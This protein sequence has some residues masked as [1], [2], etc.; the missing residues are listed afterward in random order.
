MPTA[1][2]SRGASRPVTRP[3]LDD[4]P[5]LFLR[6][7]RRGDR[8]AREELIVRFLPLARK[9]A[10]RYVKPCEPIEDLVQVASIGL[11][12][13]VDRFD[14][15]RGTP[16]RSFAVPTILGEIKRY[17]RDLGWSAHVPRAMHDAAMRIQAAERVLTAQKGRS[18]TISELAEYLELDVDQVIDALTAANSHYAASLDVPVSDDSEEPATIVET[19]GETDERFDLI[20]TNLTIARIA[21]QLP[22]LE[23]LVVGL[24]FDQELT[25]REIAKLIG[26]SQMQVSRILR[27]ALAQIRELSELDALP[28]EGQPG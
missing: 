26:V 18:P 7:R 25:Q 21:R 6:W 23:R 8:G 13:A 11:I 20:D 22:A 17:F 10:V 4:S 3:R 16:F 19:L 2:R 28:P 9:L 24:R 5:E 15:D 27:R 1:C 12:K 14:P